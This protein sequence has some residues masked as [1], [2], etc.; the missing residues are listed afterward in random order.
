MDVGAL[1]LGTISKRSLKRERWGWIIVNI[2]NDDDNNLNYI[3]HSCY[4]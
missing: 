3:P 2:K 4:E 1:F